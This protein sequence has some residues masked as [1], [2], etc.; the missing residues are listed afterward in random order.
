VPLYVLGL[1]Q[2]AGNSLDTVPVI[3]GLIATFLGYFVH[4]NV[5]FRL[6]PLEW[7]IATPGF[8]HW[9]HTNDGPELINRNYAATLPLIDKLFGTLYLPKTWPGKYGINAKTPGGLVEQLFDPLIESEYPS[10]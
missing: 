2:P 5:R 10:H 8:H 7:L 9:H 3:I 4:A 6:G 1:A